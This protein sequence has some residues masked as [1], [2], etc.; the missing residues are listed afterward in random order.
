[1]EQQL[2]QHVLSQTWWIKKTH[3]PPN[4]YRMHLTVSKSR[5]WLMHRLDA[6]NLVTKTA[7]RRFQTPTFW[8]Y[9]H[10]RARPST[11]LLKYFSNTKTII[12]TNGEFEY[13]ESNAHF[14]RCYSRN[15]Q[16]CKTNVLHK[17]AHAN[18]NILWHFIINS[19]AGKLNIFQEVFKSAIYLFI[20]EMYI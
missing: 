19:I 16:P 9:L 6:A 5:P 12:M 13:I 20:I 8:F 17:S 18:K 3:A 10:D 2:H 1:M 15:C 11:V 14:L 7:S 4:A